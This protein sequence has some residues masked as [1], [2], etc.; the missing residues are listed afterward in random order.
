NVNTTGFRKDQVSFATQL[1]SA[2]MVHDANIAGRRT[3]L[4]DDVYY[5]HIPVDIPVMV[6]AHYTAQTQGNF[7]FTDNPLDAAI[8]GDGYFVLQTPEGERYTRA[9]SFR[10]NETGYIVNQSGYAVLAENGPINAIG[11]DIAIGESGEVVVDGALLDRLRVVTV[12]Q[13]GMLV[14]DKESFY[15]LR[16][17]NGTVQNVPYPVVHSGLLES[18]NVKS[19]EELN[20]MTINM[21]SFEASSKAVKTIERIVSRAI[22]GVGKA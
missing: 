3:S 13:P 14:K 21:R 19:I 10:L 15:R 2:T 7:V 5:G 12:D 6:D 11:E 17:E 9:G 22:N 20:A 4:H 16:D 1:D 18:S 8:E